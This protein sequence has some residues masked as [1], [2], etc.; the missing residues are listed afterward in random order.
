MAHLLKIS[1]SLISL[2]L[3]LFVIFFANLLGKSERI[4]KIG[5]FLGKS[6]TIL[7]SMFILVLF[8]NYYLKISESL[9]Y[10]F[11]NILQPFEAE[12][13][14]YILF[15]LFVIISFLIIINI[16]FFIRNSIKNKFKLQDK[17]SNIITGIAIFVLFFPYTFFIM[18]NIDNNAPFGDFLYSNVGIFFGIPLVLLYTNFL[19]G[20]LRNNFKR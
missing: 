10:L 12:V 5:V 6:M 15:Y 17:T 7:I 9:S 18:E 8:I 14:K 19:I 2:V 20:E 3:F 1:F 16:L 11:I 4:G 13:N